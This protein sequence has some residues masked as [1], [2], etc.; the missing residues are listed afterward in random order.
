M[1]LY[2]GGLEYML[3]KIWSCYLGYKFCFCMMPYL[4]NAGNCLATLREKSSNIV[5]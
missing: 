5:L 3:F 2:E 1:E 4:Y